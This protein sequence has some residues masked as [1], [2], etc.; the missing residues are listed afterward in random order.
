MEAFKANFTLRRFSNSL[1]FS[2]QITIYSIYIKHT[3]VIFVYQRFTVRTKMYLTLL[4]YIL[5]QW[6]FCMCARNWLRTTWQRSSNLSGHIKNTH[7]ALFDMCTSEQ[8][9]RKGAD[10]LG[11]IH[12]HYPGLSYIKRPIIHLSP[13][14]CQTN[15]SFIAYHKP[16]G[17]YKTSSHSNPPTMNSWQPFT[18]SRLLRHIENQDCQQP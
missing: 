1:G 9:W 15:S 2:K 18:F 17:S 7:T 5:R 4:E 3:R 10:W 12:P 11:N 14:Q 16:K 13:A 8:L 6:K